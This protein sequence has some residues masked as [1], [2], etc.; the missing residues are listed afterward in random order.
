[1]PRKSNKII[2]DIEALPEADR[3]DGYAHPRETHKLFGHNEAKEDLLNAWRSGR[4]HHAWIL[5]GPSGIGKATLAYHMARLILQHDLADGLPTATYA[6]SPDSPVSKQIAALSHPNLF[7]L[8]RIWDQKSGRFSTIIPVDEVRRLKH[9]TTMTGQAGRW[10][11]VIIDRADELNI[12]SANALLKILEE[13]P[14][15]CLYFLI[16]E[17]LGRLPITIRSRCRKLLLNPLSLEDLSLAVQNISQANLENFHRI[18]GGSVRQTLELMQGHGLEYY[19][20]LLEHLN[21]LPKLDYTRLYPSIEKLAMPSASK[22]FEIFFSI[23][24]NIMRRIIRY[25]VAPSASQD[26]E[27]KIAN[28]LMTQETLALWAELW[29]TIIQEKNQV[30]ALNLD[31]KNFLVD[32]FHKMQNVA[33]LAAKA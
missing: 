10:R 2:D 15:F 31:K 29:E 1:M 21:A 27:Q 33:I 14:D 7:V 13:P 32:V 9:F 12:S 19:K 18:S 25:G 28:K 24:G 22:D 11:V 16:T 30:L 17:S 20:M 3:L 8:R 26:T 5:S 6:L 4:M 23:L